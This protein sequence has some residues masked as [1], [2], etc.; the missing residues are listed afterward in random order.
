ME[1]PHFSRSLKPLGVCGVL[2]FSLLNIAPVHANEPQLLTSTSSCSGNA[3]GCEQPTELTLAHALRLAFESNRDLAGAAKE[4]GAME[5]TVTQAGLFNNPVFSADAEDMRRSD[6]NTTLRISQLIELGGKRSARMAASSLA[7][8]V[9]AQDYEIKRRN[10]ALGVAQGFSDV[11]ATQSQLRFAEQSVQLAQRVAEATAKRVQAGKVSPAEATRAKLALASAGIDLEQAKREHNAARRRLTAFWGNPTPQFTQ[12]VGD[13]ESTVTLPE[14]TKLTERLN[15]HP[16]L[17]RSQQEVALRQAAMEVE[18]SKRLPDISVSA[19]VRKYAL[20]DD[21]GYLVGISVP[22]P[23]FNRNQGNLLTAQQRLSQAEDLEQATQTRMA[24]ELAQAYEALVAAET[25][26][27]TLR[28]E[29]LPSAKSAYEA[30]NK[31][32]EYGKFG[33]LDVLDAQRT[34]FQNQRLY[35]RSLANYQRLLTELEY[36]AGEPIGNP[37]SSASPATGSSK[38]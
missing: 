1:F 24:S 4:I 26:I 9:A 7:R 34:L 16:A 30:A 21:K 23:L 31:G 19:G 18:K 35:V 13:L 12:A 33:F 27:K 14:L 5:G 36:L 15:A 2:V 22:L 32:F 10:V 20:N 11:L 25:E 38:Q 28:N 3:T 29:V 37:P 17:V 6:R 8:D